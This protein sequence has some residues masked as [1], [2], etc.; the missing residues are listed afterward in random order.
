MN[1]V[2]ITRRLDVIEGLL[3]TKNFD[4]ALALA[5][6]VDEAVTAHSANAG[7]VRLPSHLC[8]RAH[9]ARWAGEVGRH[10]ETLAA[11]DESRAHASVWRWRRAGRP[12]RPAGGLL[13]RVLARRF[14]AVAA[15][16]AGS[17]GV[18]ELLLN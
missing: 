16:T 11:T 17:D 10:L 5:I 4:V 13:G 12:C 2:Q 1:A 6:D 3:R 14:P 7:S 18:S 9:S 15:R 8:M